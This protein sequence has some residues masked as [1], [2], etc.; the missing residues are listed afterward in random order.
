[1]R[2]SNGSSANTSSCNDADVLVLRHLYRIL[3]RITSASVRPKMNVL[4]G[5]V[6][7]HFFNARSYKRIGVLAII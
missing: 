6:L 2:P 5:I 3:K 4:C 7:K 1:M